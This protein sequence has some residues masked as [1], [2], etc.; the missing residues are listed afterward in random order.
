MAE[1]RM[2]AKAVVESDDFLDLPATTQLLYFHLGVQAD[3]DGFVDRYRAI[4]RTVG[5]SRDDLK[6]LCAKGYVI[7]FESGVVLI[8]HWRLNNY[9][10]S[11]R[12]HETVHLAEKEIVK[13]EKNGRYTIGIPLV[14]PDK[15]RLD[16]TSL[17]ELP[18]Q[19]VPPR[20]DIKNKYGDAALNGRPPTPFPIDPDTGEYIDREGM[21]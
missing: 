14:Y 21:L 15:I 19:V 3:D 8:S 4:M 12:Y 13:V 1:K 18:L 5:S 6:L 2:F 20:E 9:I 17:G 7:L 11:D 10:R 16:E